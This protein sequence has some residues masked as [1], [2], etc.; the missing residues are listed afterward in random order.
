VFL[1]KPFLFHG[2]KGGIQVVDN[3]TAIPANGIEVMVWGT[4]FI[5]K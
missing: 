2:V 1:K 3:G 5:L 4:K